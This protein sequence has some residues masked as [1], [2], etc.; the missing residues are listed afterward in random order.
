MKN[1]N[2]DFKFSI[3]LDECKN[4]NHLNQEFKDFGQRPSSINNTVKKF[5]DPRKLPQE[6][7]N[8]LKYSNTAKKLVV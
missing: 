4:L 5:N 6:N 1:E 3:E 7:E 8:N 2:E